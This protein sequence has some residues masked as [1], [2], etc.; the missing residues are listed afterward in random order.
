MSIILDT[1]TITTGMVWKDRYQY[2]PVVQ[3]MRRTLGGVAIVEYGPLSAGVPVTLSSL[4]DQ[5][6]ITKLQLDALQALAVVPGGVYTLTI[7]SDSYQ[8]MFR[9]QDEPAVEFEPL[10]PRTE[11]LEDDWFV[12]TIKLMTV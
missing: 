7:G 11:P 2:A 12:G 8:V 4:G 3:S 10:I 6:W 9:H 5:G 1:V